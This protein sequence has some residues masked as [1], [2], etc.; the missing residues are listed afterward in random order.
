MSRMGMALGVG[1][2]TMYQ[3]MWFPLLD[4]NA[5]SQN[6]SQLNIHPG[7]ADTICGV[8]AVGASG[9]GEAA[10]CMVA[11]SPKSSPAIG[12]LAHFGFAPVV[13]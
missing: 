2:V 4:V 8:E 10:S 3:T 9:C 7:W 12:I 5:T 6:S 11:A 1:A 13:P